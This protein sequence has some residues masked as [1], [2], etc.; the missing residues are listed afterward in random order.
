MRSLSCTLGVLADFRDLSVLVALSFLGLQAL[1]FLEVPRL[2]FCDYQIHV[3]YDVVHQE[4][5]MM[6]Q[7]YDMTR[8]SNSESVHIQ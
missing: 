5:H 6:V 2:D 1:G 4:S 8:T 7:G 3:Y